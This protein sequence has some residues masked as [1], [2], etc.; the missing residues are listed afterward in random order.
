MKKYA[1]ILCGGKGTR[2]WPLSTPDKPKQFAKVFN[3]V[4]LMQNTLDRIPND[5]GRIFVSNYRLRSE[6]MPYVRDTDIVIFES[7]SK[8]TGQ[9][10]CLAVAYLK[11]FNLQCPIVVLPCDHIFDQDKF[12]EI[13]ERSLSMADKQIVTFGIKPTNPEPGY[14]YIKKRD[15][16]LIDYFIEKPTVDQATKLIS[17]G[18]LWN[19]GV[20]VFDLDLANDLFNK[21]NHTDYIM[22][23]DAVQNAIIIDNEVIVGNMYNNTKSI[24][25][26][27]LIMEKIN[28]GI[29]LEYDGIWSDVGDWKTIHGLTVNENNKII[30]DVVTIDTVSSYIYT[31]VGKIITVGVQ[32]LVI[33]KSGNNLLVMNRNKNDEFRKY[34]QLM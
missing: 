10:I 12:R 25:F 13:L 3:D 16:N 27:C 26:D 30:G 8:N 18:C 19:S 32:D 20:F 4:T 23:Q 21:L 17:A 9:A 15:S 7:S 34:I 31:D 24:S 29:V 11:Q 28:D 22:C 14:G 33:V 6:L 2:L 1:I 5:F